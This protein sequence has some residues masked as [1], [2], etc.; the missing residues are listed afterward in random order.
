MTDWDRTYDVIKRRN[1]VILLVLAAVSGLFMNPALTLG[2]ILG[3]L[4]SI[5]NLSFLQ[6]T[7]RQS[8]SSERKT[9]TKKAFLIIKSFFR[10]IILGG[11]IYLLITRGLVDPIGLAVGLSTVVFSI[12]SFGI[13][14]A[15]KERIGGAT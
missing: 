12:V 14:N 3:G 6:H 8:F 9:G 7:V 15:Y 11:S 2:V 4:I 10:L 13:H 1:W 5:T